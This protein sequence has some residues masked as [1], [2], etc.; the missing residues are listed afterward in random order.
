MVVR[1]DETRQHDHPAVIHD[2]RAGI[3]Q[4]MAVGRDFVILDQKVGVLHNAKDILSNRGIH[5]HEK[6]GISNRVGAR[7]EPAT[8]FTI[9]TS[10]SLYG[11][12]VRPKILGKYVL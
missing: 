6:G 8:A 1:I 7:N 10:L 9:H 3:L 5:R 11:S 12:F 4:L 2:L